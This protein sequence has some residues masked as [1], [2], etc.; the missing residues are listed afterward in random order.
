[1]DGI[2]GPHGDD[3]GAGRDCPA[4]RPLEGGRGKDR[5][6]KAES[7]NL[8]ATEEEQAAIREMLSRRA[9]CAP[10]GAGVG[11]AS[12]LA[13]AGFKLAAFVLLVAGVAVGLGDGNE[14]DDVGCTVAQRPGGVSH[15]GRSA[16]AGE[17]GGGKVPGSD[18][19]PAGG[20]G[21]GGPGGRPECEARAAVCAHRMPDGQCRRANR[22][23]RLFAGADEVGEITARIHR[24]IATVRK[25]LVEA[26]AARE[27]LQGS[28]ELDDEALRKI[29]AAI[30]LTGKDEPGARGAPLKEVFDFYCVKG[31]SAQEVS[32]KLG[33]SKATVMNRLATLRR[34][35]GVPASELRAYKPFFEQTEKVLREPRARRV[36]PED[37]IYG[38]E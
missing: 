3:V 38:G 10:A 32:V 14:F 7:K 25:E 37:A 23:C 12:T 24:E 5:G 4:Q 2:D 34:I 36:R 16:Q 31:F 35:A 9:E 13:W 30:L 6:Q 26:R 22:Q 20:A 17:R 21:D 28:D 18:G 8:H 33:C 19:G 15:S 29:Y 1:M 11:R 27:R